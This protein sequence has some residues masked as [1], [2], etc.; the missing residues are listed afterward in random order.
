M[1]FICSPSKFLGAPAWQSERSTAPWRLQN[2]VCS[3]PERA[4]AAASAA[5]R[6]TPE[7][8]D[9]KVKLENLKMLHQA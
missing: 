6:E 7:E 2:K 1:T 8:E 5:S 3:R 9:V 4:T